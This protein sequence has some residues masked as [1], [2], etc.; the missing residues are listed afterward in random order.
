MTEQYQC[1]SYYDDGV[2]QYCTCNKC[3]TAYERKLSKWNRGDY[4]ELE[5][6][7]YNPNRVAKFRRVM[8]AAGKT[9]PLNAEIE[10]G[11]YGEFLVIDGKASGSLNR[12]VAENSDKI[13]AKN[14]AG[15]V[16]N[17][18]NNKIDLLDYAA[19]YLDKK[20]EVMK[21]FRVVE[22]SLREAER[23]GFNHEASNN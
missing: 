6:M 3:G 23:E 10:Q 1:Q 12:H 8:E 20:V 19:D 14:A 13:F 7:E 16:F 9:F 21:G 17:A 4:I 5:S 2:L 18:I 15:H 11:L 22:M